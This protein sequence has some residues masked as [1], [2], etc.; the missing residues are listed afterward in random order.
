[1]KLKKIASLMLA[2]VMAISM[3]TACGDNGTND[4]GK[5]EGETVVAGYS[6]TFA[7]KLGKAVTDLDHVSF[8]DNTADAAALQKSLNYISEQSLSVLSME[9]TVDS[10]EDKN[11]ADVKA[12]VADFIDAAKIS[13][14]K[15]D[16]VDLKMD[17][18]ASN[19][20]NNTTVKDGAI[21]VV[22]GAVGADE[23]VKQVAAELKDNLKALPEHNTNA[24]T[25]QKY[26]YSYVVS[27]SVATKA[28]DSTYVGASNSATFVAVTVTRTAVQG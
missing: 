27:V 6:T 13:D 2:G 1:M 9:R 16:A 3:L 14:K 5:G 20:I 17:W 28:L 12:M 23:A 4:E 22:N 11:Q 21:Y 18:Y 24:G 8:K 7:D 10:L 26:D 25:V 19:M 15:I